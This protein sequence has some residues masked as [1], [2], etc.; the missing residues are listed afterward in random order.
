MHNSAT[1]KKCPIIHNLAM[2][3]LLED[4]RALV[5]KY[6]STM[7]PLDVLRKVQKISELESCNIALHKR[8]QDDVFDIFEK[9]CETNQLIGDGDR[10]CKLSRIVSQNSTKTNAQFS[11]EGVLEL[12]ELNKYK[13]DFGLPSVQ[14]SVFNV[15]TK[16]KKRKII[17]TEMMQDSVNL[18]YSFNELSVSESKRE[19]NMSVV[20]S[21]CR[22]INLTIS[23]SRGRSG[24]DECTLVDFQMLTASFSPSNVQILLS[25]KEN[26]E[27]CTDSQCSGTDNEVKCGWSLRSSV[28]SETE[29]SID[30]N[31]DADELIDNS[32]YYHVMV[33]CDSINTVW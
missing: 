26:D 31:L 33:D 27:S 9:D 8:L 17:R 20:E 14:P 3:L 11:S 23:M 19:I 2:E 18:I 30:E 13:I 12:S 24:M 22:S 6:E 29:N 28:H 21:P 32:D 15:Q 16:N 7:E 10:L 1:C 5:L 25:D 4:V